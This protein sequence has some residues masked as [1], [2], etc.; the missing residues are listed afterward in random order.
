MF[1]SISGE[2][3]TDPV[4]SA[5]SGHLFEKSLIDKYLQSEDKCPVTGEPLTAADLIPVVA[6][7]TPRPRPITA[8]SIPGLLSHFQTEWDAVMLETFTLKQ[9]L[10]TTRKELSQVLY[11]HDAACRVIARLTRERD[12]ARAMLA[13][14]QGQ[15]AERAAAA[16]AG[17]S[18]DVEGSAGAPLTSITEEVVAQMTSKGK[19]LSKGRKKRPIPE[20]L[21][22]PAAMKEY[23]CQSSATPHAS[24]KQGVTCVALHPT[25]P[26]V[27]VSGGVDKDVIIYDHDQSQIVASLSGH[28]KKVTSV[29]F[30]SDATKILSASTDKTA[31]IW[32]A[33]DAAAV[34]FEEKASFAHEAEVTG[35]SIHPTGDYFVTSG[36]NATWSFHSIEY[37]TTL[38]AVSS[39]DLTAAFND[40]QFHPDGL[41][42][43]VADEA[44]AVR[45]FDMKTQNLIHTFE[46][47]TGAVQSLHFSENGY[48]M[49]SASKDKTVRL[50]DLRKLTNIKTLEVPAAAHTVKFDYSGTYL[51]A[52]TG[53]DV[54]VSVVKEWEQLNVLSGHSKDVAG[55]AVAKDAS[56]IVSVGMDR[57]IKVWS[58]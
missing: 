49:A 20:S 15:M 11:Q 5:K 40:I 47:H 56:R 6:G 39:P 33:A 31:K 43:G 32:V 29:E 51:V 17:E 54:S 45:M 57:A 10:D 53:H 48:Y 24:S 44:K 52:G 37:G 34:A 23:S 26:A 35:L 4:V 22:K 19:E 25:L 14:R 42:V 13:Q 7:Q 18:M 36:K 16:A 3:P 21:A 9:H 46:G 8:T 28:S 38:Q 1:C 55:V 30:H 2:V 12:E 50:W 27:T 58:K 41:I